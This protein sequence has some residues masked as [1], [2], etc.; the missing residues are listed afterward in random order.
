MK[1]TIDYATFDQLDLRVGKVLTAHNPDWSNKLIEL[2]VDFGSEIGQRTILTGIRQWHNPE[3]LQ[4]KS[5][6]FVVNMAER[7]MGPSASQGMLIMAE[8]EAPVLL[9]LPEE[10]PAG[11][12]VR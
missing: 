12:I 3:E 4:G 8:G 9:P 6:V 5:Y 2:K 11:T 7:K 10:I 1:P